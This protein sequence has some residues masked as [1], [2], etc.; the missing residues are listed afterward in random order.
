MTTG[1]LNVRRGRLQGA[2]DTI[3]VDVDDAIPIGGVGRAKSL[4]WPQSPGR[5]YADIDPAEGPGDVREDPLLRIE[6]AH[7]NGPSARIAVAAQLGGVGLDAIRHEVEQGDIGAVGAQGA[8][9]TGA[10]AAAG[11]G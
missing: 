9:Q 4:E 8:S 7:V 1:F 10:E 3:E 5:C 2:P 6:V 11:T